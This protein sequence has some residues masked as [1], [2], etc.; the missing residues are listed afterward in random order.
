MSLI[1]IGWL[2]LMT[3][4]SV[5]LVAKV[6]SIDK[7][8]RSLFVRSRLTDLVR[9]SLVVG[10]FGA[11]TH[12]SS[13]VEEFFVPFPEDSTL[14]FL[15]GITTTALCG[16]GT[17]FANRTGGAGAAFSP[18]DPVRT[19]TDF[20]VRVDGTIIVI[21]HFEDD[22]DTPGVVESYESAPLA[23]IADGSV[24]PSSVT[25][26]IYG[27]GD[28]SNGAVPGVT[29][30]AEDVLVQGQVVVFEEEITTA[31][32]LNDLEIRGR[33]ISAPGTGTRTEDGLDGGDRIFATE[34]INITRAQWTTGPETL[35]AGA[36][37]LFPIAQWGTSFTVPVGEDSGTFEFQWTGVTVMAAN[38]NTSI[39][40]DANG[41][42]DFD[43]ADDVDSVVI[44]R[45]Q[46]VEIAGRNDTGGQTTC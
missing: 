15:G 29:T 21:D 40:I 6:V 13:A 28:V 12:T 45:G 39:S 38:D 18:N 7:T 46:T 23:S 32:Q 11:F 34:T 20:V 8:V 25:T 9:K 26:R 19:V 36:F 37:E 17:D 1:A 10:M 22:P 31:T 5:G 44:N 24:A 41:D 33:A 27:D 4:K 43:D 30:D 35:F 16:P 2:V 14:A 3:N 42:G